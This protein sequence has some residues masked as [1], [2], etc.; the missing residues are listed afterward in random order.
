MRAEHQLMAG[1]VEIYCRASSFVN[2]KARIEGQRPAH[3][4][5]QGNALSL[6]GVSSILR[7]GLSKAKGKAMSEPNCKF[8]RRYEREFEENAVALVLKGRSQ[9]EVSRDLGVSAW[10]L[11]EC[12]K[13]AKSG[14]ALSHSKTLEAESTEPFRQ[15]PAEGLSL[16][17]GSEPS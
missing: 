9:G 11:G 8:A 17:K 3:K 15:A 4:P 12:V 14:Q 2:W 7:T 6:H 1:H 16:S 10:S 13:R 5:A